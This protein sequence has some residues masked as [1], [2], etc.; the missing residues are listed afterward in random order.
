MGMPTRNT[1][2][3]PCMVKSRLNVAGGTRCRPGHAS[4]SRIAEASRPAT[5]RKMMPVVTY[6]IP[7]RLWSTVTTHSCSAVS[8]DPRVSAAAV[9]AIERG[10][11][12]IPAPSFQRE[13]VGGHRV[14]VLPG[15]L[16]GRH[17]RA[18]L[19]HG[20]IVDPGPQ[21]LGCV[22]GHARP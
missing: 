11:T 18:R 16:H 7:R 19:Q 20:G 2:V 4:C 13:Q 15:E 1:I 6:M 9:G 14:Q 8:T 22:G 21:H 17:E 10:R 3:V 12:L 5:T